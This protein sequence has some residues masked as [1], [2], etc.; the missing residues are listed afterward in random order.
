MLLHE[1][2]YGQLALRLVPLE[3]FITIAKLITSDNCCQAEICGQ[4]ALILVTLANFI[5]SAKLIT[6]TIANRLDNTGDLP[7]T[8]GP[9]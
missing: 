2:I 1:E 4:L 5:T 8:Y 7:N 3:N 9:V 6:Q